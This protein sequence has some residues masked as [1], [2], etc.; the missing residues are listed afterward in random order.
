[1]CLNGNTDANDILKIELTPTHIHNKHSAKCEDGGQVH[2]LGIKTSHSTVY[3]VYGIVDLPI[4]TLFL[5]S[6]KS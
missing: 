4:V 2:K 1:M 3:W 6:F 5:S